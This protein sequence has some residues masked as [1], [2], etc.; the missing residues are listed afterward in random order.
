MPYH[1]LLLEVYIVWTLIGLALTTDESL[2]LHSNL[3]CLIRLKDFGCF[4]R[5][6]PKANIDASD[7]T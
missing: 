3:K 1:H 6:T 5:R 2:F 7:W 4:P